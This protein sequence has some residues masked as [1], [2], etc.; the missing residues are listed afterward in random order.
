MRGSNYLAH[1]RASFDHDML[2]FIYGRMRVF[3]KYNLLNLFEA[4]FSMALFTVYCLPRTLLALSSAAVALFP[5]NK[6]IV[7]A[8]VDSRA[9]ESRKAIDSRA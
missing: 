3:K 8:K 4:R 5:P 1:Y 6:M 2:L 7:R 9:D